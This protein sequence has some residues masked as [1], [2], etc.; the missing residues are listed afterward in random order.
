MRL[1]I[2]PISIFAEHGNFIWLQET[3]GE[4][5]TLIGRLATIP[6]RQIRSLPVCDD[7]VPSQELGRLLG[8][9]VMV[10][11]SNQGSTRLPG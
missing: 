11:G 9:V 7:V 4:H 3:G 10:R 1:T 2:C 8:R 6:S 5:Y